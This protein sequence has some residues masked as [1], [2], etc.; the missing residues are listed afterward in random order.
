MGLVLRIHETK[1]EIKR[2]P[3]IFKMS[4]SNSFPFDVLSREHTENNTRDERQYEVSAELRCGREV[5]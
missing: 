3:D 1:V 4:R 2:E 5:G